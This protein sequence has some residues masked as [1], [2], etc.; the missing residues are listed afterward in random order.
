MKCGNREECCGVTNRKGGAVI[1]YLWCAGS[2]FRDAF[3]IGMSV[4]I[5]GRF[6]FSGCH[7]HCER[8]PKLC[9]QVTVRI[10]EAYNRCAGLKTKFKVQIVFVI[11]LVI[12]QSYDY[13]SIL[14]QGWR[15]V[16]QA[17]KKPTQKTK[18]AAPSLFHFPWKWNVEFSTWQ[19][20]SFSTSSFFLHFPNECL[21]FGSIT[22]I[23]QKMTAQKLEVFHS[24]NCNTW[25]SNEIWN[26]IFF[27]FAAKNAVSLHNTPFVAV[28][29]SRPFSNDIQ[30]AGVSALRSRLH[31]GISK[32][33]NIDVRSFC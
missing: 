28:G 29:L 8:D 14:L 3:S 2:H 21:L 5:A 1:W 23:R 31:S 18:K 26:L 7:Q 20:N 24:S 16:S 11:V 10:S 30:I 15:V 12:K 33:F 22:E 27:F 17:E 32:T 19:I 25:R 13:S 6:F 9:S 4:T